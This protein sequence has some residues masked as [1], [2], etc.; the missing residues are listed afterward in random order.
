MVHLSLKVLEGFG[1]RCGEVTLDGQET[2]SAEMDKVSQSGK[3]MH[4]VRKKENKFKVAALVTILSP[5]DN[6]LYLQVGVLM[7]LAVAREGK[8]P[9]S[10]FGNLPG[11]EQLTL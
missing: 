2:S 1:G 9:T 10:L 5:F 7:A 8:Q 4:G 6:F 3:S 11:G